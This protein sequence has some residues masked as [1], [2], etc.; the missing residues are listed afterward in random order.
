[1]VSLHP[2]KQHML[3]H[4]LLRTIKF[5]HTTIKKYTLLLCILRNALLF[6]SIPHCNTTSDT[7]GG[8]PHIRQF[9]GTSCV[10]QLNSVLA[11]A[12][13]RRHQIPRVKGTAPHDCPHPHVHRKFKQSPVLLFFFFF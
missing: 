13:C 5:L 12:T 2:E 6:L 10:L 3:F 9:C 7:N 1:M 11:L 4:T 8:V